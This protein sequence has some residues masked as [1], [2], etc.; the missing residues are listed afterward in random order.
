MRAF[1]NAIKAHNAIG[2]VDS[3]IGVFDDIDADWTGFFAG[4]SI[5]TS[6]STVSGCAG[7]G[8]EAELANKTESCTY[9]AEPAA[10]RA[11][12]E[13]GEEDDKAKEE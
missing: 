12:D 10:V 13:E 3:S 6:A 2:V 7:D 4:L 5:A 11:S 8:E 9:G 1:R